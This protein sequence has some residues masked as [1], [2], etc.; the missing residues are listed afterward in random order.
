MSRSP[1]ASC[2]AFAR[3][4]RDLWQSFAAIELWD[5]SWSRTEQR[6]R[7][8]AP[9]LLTG[10]ALHPNTLPC[11]ANSN[12]AIAESRP[13]RTG[14]QNAKAVPLVRSRLFQ[15]PAAQSVQ[16]RLAFRTAVPRFQDHSRHALDGT[17]AGTLYAG[18]RVDFAVGAGFP[19]HHAG[20]VARAGVHSRVRTRRLRFW[21]GGRR[22][23][24]PP[25]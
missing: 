16:V 23:V 17:V 2:P 13:A 1:N 7:R 12:D 6:P 20:A 25:I 19:V 4:P 9:E 21:S 22:T 24:A 18:D 14:M 8:R 11:P 5:S 10:A 15:I 3:N